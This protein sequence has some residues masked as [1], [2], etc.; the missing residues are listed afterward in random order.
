VSQTAN[1][2]AA[3]LPKWIWQP[4]ASCSGGIADGETVKPLL[5]RLRIV[6]RAR[7]EPLGDAIAKQIVELL[8]PTFWP[9]AIHFVPALPKTQSMLR[10]VRQQY[11]GAELGDTSTVENSS[12]LEAFRCALQ[13]G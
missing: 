3:G 10:L 13:S 6:R 4:S 12:A 7:L 2:D 5:A 11:L 9:N 1:H 8:G